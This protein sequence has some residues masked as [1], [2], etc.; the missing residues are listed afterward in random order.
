MCAEAKRVVF[1]AFEGVQLLD[2]VGPLE[3][4]HGANELLRLR[5]PQAPQA[6]TIS[7]ITPGGKAVRASNG[8]KIESSG[9]L[10]RLPKGADT[11][12][13]PGALN[14]EDVLSA[15]KST[16]LFVRK[17]AKSA[18]RMVAICSG[19]FFF[20]EAG[21]LQGRKVTTHWAGAE[22][23]RQRYPKIHLE[24]DQIYVRDGN[25]YTSGGVTSGMDLA[26]AL[27]GEDL[28]ER[29]ALELARWFVMY[30]RRPGGQ[31][32]FSAPLRAQFSGLSE[33]SGI[34]T[35]I[36]EHPDDD[37]S[38]GNLAKRAGMSV[39]NFARVFRHEAGMTPAQFVAQ[40]RLERSC[41]DLVGS[42]LGI[43]SV[44]LRCG[45]GSEES[46][47]RAFQKQ[48]SISPGEYRVRFRTGRANHQEASCQ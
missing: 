8:L 35:W 2:F 29:V 11:V 14:I 5:A 26:L 38:V 25:V 44:A 32:Q 45:Y 42:D 6:Y 23:F 41:H 24:S 30:V 36:L 37:L 15:N 31:S 18:R 7:I 21:L 9:S 16:P 17:A 13:V 19:T 43:K 40:A 10:S 48:F 27:V 20:A 28:G 22:L 3:I 12:V 46:L 47:R 39:R 34:V 1:V 33:V 4:F